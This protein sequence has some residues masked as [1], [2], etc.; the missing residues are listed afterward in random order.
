MSDEIPPT[1]L[2][3]DPLREL[4]DPRGRKKHRV[5]T[6]NRLKVSVL[7][8]AGRELDEIADVIGVSVPTLRKYYF[9]ELNEG[10][11]AERARSI[12]WLRDS[13]AGG[14][15][16]AQKAYIALLGAGYTLPKVDEPGDR[17][18]K[19]GK[20]EGLRQAAKDGHAGT[21]WDGLVQH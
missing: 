4:P 9:S 14:N 6:E 21:G 5:T 18:D 19:L 1:D 16:S 3:G 20:K 11:A 2:L 12:M 17:L 10:V 13:A 7:R 8:G 15:V